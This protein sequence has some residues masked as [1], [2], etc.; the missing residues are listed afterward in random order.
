MIIKNKFENK[1]T[2]CK[3]VIK[4]GTEVEWEFGIGIRHLKCPKLRN[5]S[6]E[7]LLILKKCQECKVKLEGDVFIS[8]NN[9]LCMKCWENTF[10]YKG[11][12]FG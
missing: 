1:C 9:R 5:Y 7:K 4:I 3:R 8:D 10:T 2:E 12:Y 6:Y 11:G